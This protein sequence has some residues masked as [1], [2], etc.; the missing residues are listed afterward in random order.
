MKTRIQTQRTQA[1]TRVELLVIICVLA[2][3]A[4]MFLPALARAKHKASRVNCVNNLH[5]VTTSLRVWEGDN[6]D[7]YPMYFALTNREMM[8]LISN[9][10]AYALWQTMSNQLP[11]PKV[12]LCPEDREHTPA[13]NFDIDFSDANI[14]YFAGLDAAETFPNMILDGDDNLALNDVQAKTG[15]LNLPTTKSLT[16]TKDRHY[17]N[18][19]IGMADGSVQQTTSSGLNAAVLNATNGTAA[20]TC[21]LVIP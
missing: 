20:P 18:G 14:S 6:G 3:L 5:E 15:I 9:G 7:K 10:R 8:K 2:F 19:N 13:T 17:G 1:L 4:A 12:L 21:R 16:W 11:T